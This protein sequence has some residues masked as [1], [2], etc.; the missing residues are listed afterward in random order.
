MQP[1]KV[2]M[3]GAQIGCLHAP[4]MSPMCFVMPHFVNMFVRGFSMF[5]FCF[6]PQVQAGHASRISVDMDLGSGWVTVTDNGRGIPTSMHPRT[7]A[8]PSAR[9]GRQALGV[10]TMHSATHV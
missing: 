3:H 5:Y 7:G 10:C 6:L 2:N 1:C 4:G 8:L 9:G